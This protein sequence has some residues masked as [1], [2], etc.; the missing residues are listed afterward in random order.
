M[1]EFL[2]VCWDA[3]NSIS[4]ISRKVKGMV[5]YI[6]DRVLYCWGRQGVFEGTVHFKSGLIAIATNILQWIFVN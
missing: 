3:D 6:D 4:V 5:S 1:A 2:L